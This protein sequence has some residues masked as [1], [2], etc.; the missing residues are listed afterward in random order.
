M[1]NALSKIDKLIQKI[2]YWFLVVSIIVMV[3]MATWQVICRYILHITAN[4]AEEFARLAVVWCIY[5]GAGLCCRYSEHMIVDAL[6]N[7]L[8]KFLQ[9]ALKIITSLC[10]CALGVV[11]II[12]GIDHVQANAMDFTT[13]L[14]Y[15]RNVFYLPAP[16]TGGLI[17]VYTINEIVQYVI[18][19]F[20]PNLG[21][22]EAK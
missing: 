9:F 19:T 5:L 2:L 7:I 10:V 17:C 8:P 3:G 18:K 6:I 13:S 21:E 20:R 4:Y 1:L 14:G 15:C 11:L 12:Y 16:I 22:S